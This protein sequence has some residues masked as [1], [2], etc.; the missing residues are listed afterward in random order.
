M[1]EVS[2]PKFVLLW[3]WV[4]PRPSDSIWWS[5][6]QRIRRKWLVLSTSFHVKLAPFFKL[7][8]K[9][10]RILTHDA[11]KLPQV[12]LPW[13]VTHWKSI[14]VW[15]PFLDDLS[16]REVGCWSESVRSYPD[17]TL[18]LLTWS[19]EFSCFEP[20]ISAVQWASK[21][22]STGPEQTERFP[23]RQRD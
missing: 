7:T 14:L 15:R 3:F 18:L 20:G 1:N 19:F 21:A 9:F 22:H 17:H 10:L 5:M 12:F 13:A 4:F 23:E 11:R 6:W 16:G 8:A 2:W